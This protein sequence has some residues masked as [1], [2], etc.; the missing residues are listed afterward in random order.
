MATTSLSVMNK[1]QKQKLNL[2]LL[3]INMRTMNSNLN[4][5]RTDLVNM[6]SNKIIS[7]NDSDNINENI[8]SIIDFFPYNISINELKSS[9]YLSILSE[10]A[11]DNS[12]SK[13]KSEDDVID[14]IFKYVDGMDISDTA[15]SNLMNDSDFI[16][17][18]LT[19]LN[20]YRKAT[21]KGDAILNNAKEINRPR[22]GHSI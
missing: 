10:L 15:K 22:N 4:S 18:N 19:D 21:E 16:S 5:L 6:R 1:D 11:F 13:Y 8:S 2:E 9:P 7:Q 12:I 14:L 3:K 20:R 17:D